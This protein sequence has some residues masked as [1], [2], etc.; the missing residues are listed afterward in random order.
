[1]KKILSTLLVLLAIALPVQSATMYIDD[2][3]RVNIRTGPEI[4]Y[5]I[6]KS[7]V[8]GVKVQVLETDEVR[9]WTKIR[10]PGGIQGWVPSRFLVSDPIAAQ[11]LE[12]ALITLKLLK[13]KSGTLGSAFEKVKSENTQLKT[14]NETLTRKNKSLAEQLDEITAVS[15]NAVHLDNRNR[16]LQ[17]LNQ[18]LQNEIDKLEADNQRLKDK[19]E[20]DLMLVGGGL[21]ALGA[22]IAIIVPMMKRTR[23]SDSWA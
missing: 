12:K 8:S 3:L 14:D 4:S 23:K 22:L 6:L 7:V 15:Q 5:R 9:K 13:E 21:V 1:M 2:K 18:E 11:R 16:E 17:E 20:T 19:S 10:E